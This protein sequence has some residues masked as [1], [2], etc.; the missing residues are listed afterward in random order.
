[1][2]NEK[3]RKSRGDEEKTEVTSDEV[4]SDQDLDALRVGNTQVFSDDEVVEDTDTLDLS[5][6]EMVSQPEDTGKGSHV[7]APNTD[8]MAMMANRENVKAMLKGYSAEKLKMLI[9]MA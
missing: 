4:L 2:L 7:S 3:I 1:M 9:E 5:D 6:V 8:Q